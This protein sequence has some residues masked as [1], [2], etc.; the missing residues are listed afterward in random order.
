[1]PATQTVSSGLG[2]RVLPGLLVIGLLGV[3]VASA[4]RFFVQPPPGPRP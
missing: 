4:V 3:A 1:M 2:G